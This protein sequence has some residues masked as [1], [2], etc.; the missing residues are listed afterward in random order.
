ML[1]RGIP[2]NSMLLQGDPLSFM[3]SQGTE[4]NVTIEASPLNSMLL[5]GIPWIVYVI[6]SDSMDIHMELDSPCNTTQFHVITFGSI[7]LNAI[8]GIPLNYMLLEGI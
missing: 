6:T 7:K 4:F 3:L 1:F 8:T 2:L 5:Q